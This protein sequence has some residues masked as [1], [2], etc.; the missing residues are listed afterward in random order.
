[1]LRFISNTSV[2][3]L[4]KENLE[5]VSM[6]LIGLSHKCGRANYWIQVVKILGYRPEIIVQKYW[7]TILS[8]YVTDFDGSSY[9]R[10]ALETF[11]LLHGEVVVKTIVKEFCRL[12]S[13]P[14]IKTLSR[15]EYFIFLTP[16]GQLYDNSVLET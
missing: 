13:A 5:A 7:N 9:K 1:V 8:K 15:E 16:E 4:K 12:T 14:E 3:T 11:C 6:D 10:R 2:K